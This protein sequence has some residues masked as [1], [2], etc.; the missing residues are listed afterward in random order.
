[1]KLDGVDL[2]PFQTLCHSTQ[3][4]RLTL[5][6]NSGCLRR[7]TFGSQFSFRDPNKRLAPFFWLPPP[8]PQRETRVD[9]KHG[10]EQTD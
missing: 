2:F 10:L 7:A 3:R 4:V 5:P 6:R 9:P 1:M 8:S